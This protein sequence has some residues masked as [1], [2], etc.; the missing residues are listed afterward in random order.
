MEEM[1]IKHETTLEKVLPAGEKYILTHAANLNR[2]ATFTNLHQQ[3]DEQLLSLFDPLSH[4]CSW[5][6]GRYD[7]KCNSIEELKQGRFVILEFN[8]AGAEPNHVYNAGFSWGKALREFAYHWRVLYEIGKYNNQHKGIRYWGNR[9]GKRWLDQARA[10]G[11][12][13]EKY[14]REILI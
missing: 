8:G 10:H 12:L 7:L 11:A 6:Y 2:G 14:D 9:E 5:F 3:I 13:L 4:R 1:R